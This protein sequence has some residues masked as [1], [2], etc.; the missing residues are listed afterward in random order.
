M[1]QASLQDL[2]NTCI[3]IVGLGYFG[4]PLAVEFGKQYDTIGFDINSRRVAELQGGR[5]NTL[6]VE[7]GELAAASRLKF[8]SLLD[9]I[10][11][12]QIYTEADVSE[13]IKAV[14]Y[15]PKVSVEASVAN[16]V[17]WYQSYYKGRP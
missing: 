1:T 8:T 6:E 4:L 9:D 7:P 11:R 16:F 5:D 3:S 17:S 12:C 10:D 2:S 13:L 15:R 14:G